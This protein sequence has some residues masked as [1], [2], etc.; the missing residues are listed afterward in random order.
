MRGKELWIQVKSYGLGTE[1][2]D[3][4]K[5]MLEQLNM[6]HND[7]I[8]AV[9]STLVR[10]Q[11]YPKC[12]PCEICI[13]NYMH[14]CLHICRANHDIQPCQSPYAMIEYTLKLCYKRSEGYRCIDRKGL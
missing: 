14:N 8:L 10:P 12:C 2:T 9:H 3:T 7:Y 4:L 5:V 6:S 1:T 11:F 13:N